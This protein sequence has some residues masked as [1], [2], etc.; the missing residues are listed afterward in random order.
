MNKE[1]KFLTNNEREELKNI[2]NTIKDGKIRDR[3]KCILCLDKGLTP[4]QIWELLLIS[5]RTIDRYKE[6]YKNEGIDSLINTNYKAYT[7]KLS[8]EQENSIKEYIKSHLIKT[9]KEL[10]VYIENKYGIVYTPEGLVITLHRLGFVYKKTKNVP[11]K[12]DEKK[13]KEFV[14]EYE[15]LKENLNE[16]EKIYFMDGVH[17]THNSKPCYAWIEKGFERKIKSNTGRERI[18]IN[19]LYSPSDHEIIFRDDDRINAQSTINL[20][21]ELERKHPELSKIYIDR[22]SMEA[23]K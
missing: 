16:D 23:F 17:P 8:I 7:G 4:E 19:G 18:N 12:A 15:C 20:L 22:T 21:Q 9:S 3:I 14:K 2:H 1:N 5:T 6:T 11:S 13:Q 10:S